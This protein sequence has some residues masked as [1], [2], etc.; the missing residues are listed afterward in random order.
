[1]CDISFLQRDERLY[2]IEYYKYESNKLESDATWHYTQT[3]DLRD[4]THITTAA[5]AGY[6]VSL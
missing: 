3:S 5:D 2:S 4:S 6:K 1:M